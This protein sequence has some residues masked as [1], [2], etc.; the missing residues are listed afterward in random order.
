MKLMR[1]STRFRI[2]AF[3]LAAAGAPAIY[4]DTGILTFVFGPSSQ[5]AARQSSRA[6][7]ATARHWLQTAGKSLKDVQ[8][9]INSA[10]KPASF[11]L[12]ES[13]HLSLKVD[14]ETTRATVNNVLA[15]LP[16]KTNEYIIIGAHYDHLGIDP[17]LPDRKRKTVR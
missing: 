5:E 7:A 10:T 3:L 12:P 1:N 15:Y 8:D 2:T 6:A 4:A 11:P 17:A 9:Q 14:I 13:L 16:G